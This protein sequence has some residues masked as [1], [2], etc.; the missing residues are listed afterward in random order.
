MIPTQL[1][2]H[3]E[4]CQQYETNL[5]SC[6]KLVEILG[7][8]LSDIKKEDLKRRSI[9]R[10]W[11]EKV[12]EL[13]RAC[14]YL[15]EVVEG[16]RQNSMEHSIMDQESGEALQMLHCQISLLEQK[17][18][19]CVK[20]EGILKEEIGMLEG[21]SKEHDADLKKLQDSLQTHE[22]SDWESKVSIPETKEQIEQMGNV[23]LAP[24]NKYELERLMVEAHLKGEKEKERGHIAK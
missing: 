8:K 15:E 24:I 4:L 11:K 20:K 7:R 23:S 13:E 19:E 17:K 5:Q 21:V 14:W 2:L 12:Q 6:D 1:V 3:T 16:L 9:L 18:A 10:T 22:E